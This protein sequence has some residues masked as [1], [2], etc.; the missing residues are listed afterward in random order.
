MSLP[1]YATP[2]KDVVE[3]VSSN[4]CFLQVMTCTKKQRLLLQ[5]LQPN[6]VLIL[7]E[8]AVSIS[9]SSASKARTTWNANIDCG[10]L[11]VGNWWPVQARRPLLTDYAEI[12]RIA[13]EENVRIVDKLSSST[14]M[15]TQ[16]QSLIG[17]VFKA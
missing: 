13:L 3:P 6:A 14:A 9:E 16:Q 17:P 1:S 10:L 7:K 2:R 8:S 12:I 5:S 15:P 11:T 4:R